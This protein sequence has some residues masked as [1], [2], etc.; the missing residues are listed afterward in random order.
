MSKSEIIILFD[1]DFYLHK[2]PYGYHPENPSR[3]DIVLRGLREHGL[4]DK[5][6]FVEGIEFSDV[7]KSV[8]M[9]H[10]KSYVDMVIDFCNSG[11]GY[12][13][14]DTYI[15]RESCVVAQ[16]AVAA[17]IKAVENA[18]EVREKLFFALVR[19]PGHHAGFSGK[20]FEAPTQGFCIFNNIAI[21][22]NHIMEKYR[23]SPVVIVDID[24]HHG[25]GT[26]EIFWN[27]PNVI[28]I[29]IHEHGIYPGTGH[30]NDV[31]GSNAK[32]TK[33]N[34]PL[35]PFS[36]DDDYLYVLNKIIHPIISHYKP[37]LVAISAGFDAYRDDGL[38]NMMLTERFYSIFGAYLRSLSKLGISIAAIL[39][40]G[41]THGLL[42]GLP[43]MLKGFIEYNK[44]YLEKILSSATPRNN[45]VKVVDEL[46]KILRSYYT[47]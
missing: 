20:A 18:L 42:H 32:G 24:V 14:P 2:P 31:G 35:Q 4:L 36:N 17:S 43:S 40:G 28:H 39:E 15:V 37:R 29:D 46:I 23:I 44:D 3:L 1:K 5:V 33:I 41:Y 21:A 25:N 6:V 26:Q 38:A 34:I 8:L 30:I 12:I 13:D 47:L 10:E 19:P 27:N 7:L 16:K 9:V 11:G 22:V 45:T